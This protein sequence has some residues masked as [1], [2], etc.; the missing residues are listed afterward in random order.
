MVSYDEPVVV[1]HGVLY[2]AS[3]LESWGVKL[4]Q[5]LCIMVC[6]AV[7]LVVNHGVLF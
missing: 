6:Y 2:C 1:N 3:G 7:P 5:G 4:S